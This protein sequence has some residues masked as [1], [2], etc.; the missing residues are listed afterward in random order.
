MKNKVFILYTFSHIFSDLS[1]F[2]KFFKNICELNRLLAVYHNRPY[3]GKKQLLKFFSIVY[4]SS[5]YNIIL[6]LIL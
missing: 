6:E 2:Q 1:S 4:S 5:S 3:I